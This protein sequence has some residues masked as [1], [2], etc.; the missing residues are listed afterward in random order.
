LIQSQNPEDLIEANKMIK[1]LAKEADKKIALKESCK[2]ELETVYNNT[3]VLSDLLN[4]YNPKESSS[5]EAELVSELHKNCEKL[6]PRL[7]RLA[8]GV[9]EN[10]PILNEIL[11][12]NDELTKV[13][14][15]FKSM[16]SSSKEPLIANNP[17]PFNL[18]DFNSTLD[19][20]KDEKL[21]KDHFENNFN[22][23]SCDTQT[24]STCLNHNSNNSKLIDD[25]LDVSC[26]SSSISTEPSLEESI[27]S[28]QQTRSTLDELEAFMRQSLSTC[29]KTIASSNK[30]SLNDLKAKEKDL[31]GDKDNLSSNK[32]SQYNYNNKNT[33]FSPPPLVDL[34]VPLDTIKPSSRQ[35]VVLND[36]HGVRTVLNYGQNVPRE[37]V[38][39]IVITTT[40]TNEKPIS[41]L[42]FQASA[43]KVS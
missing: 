34:F 16:Q 39:A 20:T 37:D 36:E 43:P 23:L 17:L 2:S 13:I 30:L 27:T 33:T 11:A 1:S 3:R 10:D 7:F 38:T 29:Q 14:N 25:L 31:N 5:E 42:F 4:Y 32:E 24:T 19:Q 22:V 8:A 35:S 6:R 15:L 21:I 18:L 41:K 28:K 26:S 40:N 12:A 9:D